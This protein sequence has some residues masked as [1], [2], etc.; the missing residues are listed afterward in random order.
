MNTNDKKY[1]PC[2]RMVAYKNGILGI[3]E[4][5]VTYFSLDEEQRVQ[6]KGA[7]I[8]NIERGDTVTS[9]LV[10][11]DVVFAGALSGNL[12]VFTFD[13]SYSWLIS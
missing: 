4:D 12:Y 5:A 6:W 10:R 3:A 8:P 2:E 1:V 13:E 9:L 11:N 7:R